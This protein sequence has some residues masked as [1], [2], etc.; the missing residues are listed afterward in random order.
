MVNPRDINVV[1]YHAPC[2]DGLASAYVANEYAGDY[3][4]T[5]KLISFTLGARELACSIEELRERV[6]LFIDCAP[7]N[8]QMSALIDAK[9][10]VQIL[11]HHVSNMERVKM[12]LITHT[13][14]L[15]NA[16]FDM[17]LSGVGLAWNYFFAPRELPNAFA[18]IQDRDLWRFAIAQSKEF[19]AGLAARCDACGDDNES[20]GIIT[21]QLCFPGTFE[22]TTNFGYLLIELN[23][24]KIAKIATHATTRVYLYE[25]S[26]GIVLKV[27][28]INCDR[29]LVSDLGDFIT[30]N[31]DYDFAALWQYDTAREKYNI[32]LRSRG[33][34]DVR[35]ICERFGGGGHKH[36]AGCSSE[37][38]PRELFI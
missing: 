32:S 30:K 14:P 17:N 16:H 12:F 36:A 1:F 11:D 33:E 37:K 29:E 15:I 21:E 27:C 22:E 24:T 2:Q 8:D 4:L 28:I 3:A 35:V 13:T 38:H 23:N 9:T 6:V 7:S 31:Y 34:I 25:T 20:M 18:M 19:C 5:F 26:P 10:R